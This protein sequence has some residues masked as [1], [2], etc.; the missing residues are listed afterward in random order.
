[1]G[2]S[3]VLGGVALAALVGAATVVVLAN[4]GD[5]SDGA[6]ATTTTE[7]VT[8]TVTEPVHGEPGSVGVGDPYFPELGN[9]GYD[10]EHYSL[11]LTWQA[12][13]GVLDGVAT[14]EASATQDLSQFDLDLSGMEVRG[15]TVDGAP[16]AVERV[17]RELVLTPAEAI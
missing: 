14:I 9:G 15:A 17:G 10:V 16:A 6:A 4:R 8:T 7:Q 2:R 13:E 11:D 3:R 1:M 5:D 12:D